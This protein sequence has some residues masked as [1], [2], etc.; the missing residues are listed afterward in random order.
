MQKMK[1]VAELP[2]CLS[3]FATAGG[4]PELGPAL[5]PY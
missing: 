4:K 2:D 5:A 1:R 3:A